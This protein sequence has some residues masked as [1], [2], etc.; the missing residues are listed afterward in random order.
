MCKFTFILAF[1]YD[2]VSAV[3]NF[4]IDVSSSVVGGDDD[5]CANDGAAS[6]PFSLTGRDGLSFFY[7]LSQVR[8]KKFRYAKK[9]RYAK[10]VRFGSVR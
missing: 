3:L 9:V 2:A 7:L 10:M 4:V 6:L 8:Q 1:S 5:S